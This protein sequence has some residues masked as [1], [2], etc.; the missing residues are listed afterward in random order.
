MKTVG[1]LLFALNYYLCTLFVKRDPKLV[2]CL[3]TNDAGPHSNVGMTARALKKEGCRFVIYDREARARAGKLGFY[4]RYP[5]A[6]AACSVILEDNILL[7]MAFLHFPANVQVIQ[8]WHGTGTIK[9][10]GQDANTGYL[11]KLERRAN[12]TITHLIVNGP[13]QVSQYAGAFGIPAEKTAVTGLPRTDLLFA[14]AENRPASWFPGK[15]LILYAPTFRDN[16]TEHPRMMLDPETFLSALPENC[17]LGIRLHPFVAARYSLPGAVKAD[18]GFSGPPPA[19]G[20]PVPR[21]Y[22]FSDYPDLDRLL[23]Q[24]DVLVTD[25]SSTAFDFAILD[26]PMIFY[27]YDLEQFRTESRGFYQDYETMVPGPVVRTT[28]EAAQAVLAGDPEAE[29]R[30]RFFREN[31]RYTDGHSTERVTALLHDGR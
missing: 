17:I 12:R 16:E 24:T 3:M 8:L 21:V 27:A 29:R 20:T 1:Y 11:A 2:F 4:F 31:F 10:F 30:H 5:R 7:P 28:K 18:A 25:Y 6:L 14:A 22:D 19:A 23:V 13:A 15:K 26:R 9:K